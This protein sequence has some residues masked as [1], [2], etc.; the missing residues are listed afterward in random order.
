[1]LML[2]VNFFFF[3]LTTSLTTFRVTAGRHLALRCL[4][5]LRAGAWQVSPP[6]CGT[7]GPSPL[8]YLQPDRPLLRR[9]QAWTFMTALYYK[10]KLD[11]KSCACY[12]RNPLSC[13]FHI[14]SESVHSKLA[15]SVA[16][17][18]WSSTAGAAMLLMWYGIFMGHC[19]SPVAFKT[20]H[21]KCVQLPHSAE[22]FRGREKWWREQS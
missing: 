3:F 17:E 21:L 9:G 11:C 4:W 6:C 7:P 18:E 12:F 2:Y 20:Q 13:F 8:N 1:M 14:V 19:F 10:P 22:K 16:N 5:H 15:W